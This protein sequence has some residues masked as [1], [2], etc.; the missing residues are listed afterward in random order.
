MKNPECARARPGSSL[1]G[2]PKA[3]ATLTKVS[4]VPRARRDGSV[5]SGEAGHSV[6][7][8][9][10]FAVEEVLHARQQRDLRRLR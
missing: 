9:I 8:F 2:V 5:L 7:Q 6:A 3:I 1:F 10:Q 4:G